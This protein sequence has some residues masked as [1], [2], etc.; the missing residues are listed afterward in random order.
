MI[1]N[2]IDPDLY[3]ATHGLTKDQFDEL[4]AKGQIKLVWVTHQS[5]KIMVEDRK[6]SLEHETSQTQQ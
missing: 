6:E 2:R 3:M 1:V 5:Q 4:V